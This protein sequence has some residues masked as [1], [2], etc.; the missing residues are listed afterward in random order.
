M[1]D[2]N[3]V[4]IRIHDVFSVTITPGNLR[5]LLPVKTNKLKKSNLFPSI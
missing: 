3:E 2:A 5:I 4:K 1:P